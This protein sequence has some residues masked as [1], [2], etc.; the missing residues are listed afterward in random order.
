M[1]FLRWLLKT[2]F[3]GLTQF[4][5]FANRVYSLYSFKQI[6]FYTAEYK[7]ITEV[8]WGN[9]VVLGDLELNFTKADATPYNTIVLA[10]ENGTGKTSILG[11]LAN[12]LNGVSLNRSSLFHIRSMAMISQHLG[13]LMRRRAWDTMTES[14][15]QQVHIREYGKP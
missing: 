3:W 9:H 10:G 12:F 1:P 11:T 4:C 15:I 7:M 5:R 14:T 6:E 8:K 13:L 2:A